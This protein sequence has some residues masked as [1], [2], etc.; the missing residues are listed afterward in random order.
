[1]NKLISLLM[2]WA[3]LTFVYPIISEM[4][5]LFKSK[6]GLTLFVFISFVAVH[7]FSIV[8]N[9]QKL[10]I[11]QIFD[12]DLYNTLLVEFSRSFVADIA[13]TTGVLGIIKILYG[14]TYFKGIILL[15]PVFLSQF[16][17]AM[18]NSY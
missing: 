8:V 10:K 15:L 14:S 2:M 18:L 6:Y 5:P 11:S 1:M 4:I 3:S 9:K 7:L 12:K 13:V 17:R 16:L